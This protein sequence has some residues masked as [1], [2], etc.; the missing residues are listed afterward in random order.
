M[1]PSA[2]AELKH[3]DEYE[4]H[5]FITFY[6]LCAKNAGKYRAHS[7]PCQ[8]SEIQSIIT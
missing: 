4:I 8:S 7:L 6:S 1:F 3:A 2:I 5:I